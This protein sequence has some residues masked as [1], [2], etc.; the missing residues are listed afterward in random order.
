MDK[1]TISTDGL[2]NVQSL[3]AHGFVMTLSKILSAEIVQTLSTKLIK[4]LVLLLGTDHI[5][6]C[7]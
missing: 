7:Y 3:W 2:Q 4:K 1:T 6:L 5:T